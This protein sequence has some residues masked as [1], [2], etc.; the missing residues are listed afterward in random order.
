MGYNSPRFTAELPDCSMPMTFDQYSN[1]SFGCLYCFSQSQRGIGNGK[2]DYVKKANVQAADIDRIVRI[3]LD[4]DC[5][6]F[7]PYVK[8]RRVIQWGGLSDPFCNFERDRG[9]GLEILRFL[10]KIDYPVCFSTKGV[11]WTKDPRYVELFRD[12]PKWNVK[13]SIVTLDTAKAAAIEIGVPSPK[14][15]LDAIE[16]I[17]GWNGGGA[18]LRLR[19]FLLGITDPTHVPMIR[20]A[21]A[22]GATAM[23]TEFFCLE[24]RSR[25]LRPHLKAF[26]DLAGFDYFD[27]YQ[28]Y[29]AQGGYLRLNR[30]VK[31]PYVDEMEAAC[32]ATG[33]RFYVS[34]AYFKERCDN[35]SCCGLPESFNYSRGQWC[36]AL[37]IAKKNGKVYWRD[38]ETD[39]KALH[40]YSAVNSVGCQIARSSSERRASFLKMTMA[41]FMQWLWNNPGKSGQSPYRLFEG[42]LRPCGVDENGDVVYEYDK[43]RA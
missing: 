40:P 10:R 2:E 31:R 25:L 35:G 32:R 43:T 15:R 3:F 11:W 29:S 36:E 21:A 22:R 20:E 27:F 18:T 1:C 38:V 7:G 17:A 41:E 34:D 26:S 24:Q 9:V 14:A 8:Q 39:I 6:T 37:L 33:M 5:S 42:I 12:N 4:P 19:P 28:K 23:S 30:N 13:V 16:R